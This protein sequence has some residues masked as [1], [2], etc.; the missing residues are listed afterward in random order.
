[1]THLQNRQG[2][3]AKKWTIQQLADKLGISAS[4]IYKWEDGTREPCC[5][6]MLKRLDFLLR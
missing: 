1:M 2:R 5:K 4:T 3:E 6:W